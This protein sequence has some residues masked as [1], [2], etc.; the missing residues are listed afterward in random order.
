MI[1]KS[2]GGG[3]GSSAAAYGMMASI[4]N[5]KNVDEIMLDVL[6]KLYTI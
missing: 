1:N 5:R 4:D 3:S 2:D 6:D